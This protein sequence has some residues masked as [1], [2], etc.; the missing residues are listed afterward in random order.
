M[1]AIIKY[2][3]GNVQ[4]VQNALKRLGVASI[5]TNEDDLIRKADKVIFP[6]VG[7]AGS[8]MQ[9]VLEKKLDVLIKSLK[10][11][12]LGI[13]VGMQLMCKY[14]DEG[15]TTC[16]GIFDTD[17]KL[18][19]STNL[20]I[21]Q[22][23]WNNIYDLKKELFKNVLENEFIYN[24]HSYYAELSEQTIATCNYTQPYSA[25]LQ[26]NNFYAV[27][28]HPEKSSKVGEQILKNFIEL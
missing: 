10:Q 5:V 20:K 23:G 15:N 9:D 12:V 18:F 11:P 27:Q 16:M 7:H 28:F 25:A 4:S 17:I 19:K 26:K 1:I 8:A 14:S 21:P 24:V 13:C 22:M 2:N 6:G 3:A